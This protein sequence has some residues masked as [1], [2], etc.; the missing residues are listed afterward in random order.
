M[1]SRL[2]SRDTDHLRAYR[3]M[4]PERNE[5]RPCTGSPIHGTS[6]DGGMMYKALDLFCGAGGASM[7]LHRAGFDVTG[8]DIK[9]EPRYPFTFILGDALTYPLEGYDFIWASPPCQSY[10]EAM[11]HL[12]KPQPK[13]IEPMR[14]RLMNCGATWVIENVLGAPMRPPNTI[15]CGTSFGLRVHRHRVFE[16][17]FL[18]LLFAPC[19]RSRTIL[20]PHQSGKQEADLPRVRSPRP[21]KA[22]G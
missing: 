1:K 6:G 10:S 8:V 2:R 13:L 22:M 7:G 20:N 15:L 17:N 9:P 16:G 18:E 4:A 3:L 19:T 12:A 11:R 5:A 14:E 21:R